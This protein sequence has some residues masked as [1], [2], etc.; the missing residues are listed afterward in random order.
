MY[1]YV[2]IEIYNSSFHLKP[3]TVNGLADPKHRQDP[4]SI[5]DV[6]ENSAQPL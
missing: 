4:E 5:E 1:I 6:G 2:G 3:N